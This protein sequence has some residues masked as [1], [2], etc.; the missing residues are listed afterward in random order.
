MGRS[1][2]RQAAP[3]PAWRWFAVRFEQPELRLPIGEG[4]TCLQ[5]AL[6]TVRLFYF[7][8]RTPRGEERRHAENNASFARCWPCRE[9]P[10]RIRVRD[11]DGLA[12]CRSKHD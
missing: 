4:V 1:A 6:I 12:A 7:V 8:L 5:D 3:L 11:W 9:R 2:F 10:Q